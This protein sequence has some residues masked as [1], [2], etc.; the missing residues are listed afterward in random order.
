MLY[1]QLL[2]ED[3]DKPLLVL[4]GRPSP[5]ADEEPVH[6]GGGSRHATPALAGKP[7]TR[8]IEGS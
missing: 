1:E 5:A 8:I 2:A 4:V 7:Q 3:V 6:V